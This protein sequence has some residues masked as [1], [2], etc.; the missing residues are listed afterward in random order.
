VRLPKW[1]STAPSYRALVVALLVIGVCVT[2]AI[3]L[4]YMQGQARDRA[5]RRLANANQS[6]E[7]VVTSL[8]RDKAQRH[9][10]RCKAAE[11]I[12]DT[13]DLVKTVPSVIGP[14]GV[15]G[16]QG[17][18][19]LPGAP[20]SNGKD[21]PPGPPGGDGKDGAPG[22]VG[23]PGADGADGPPGPQGSQGPPGPQGS[24]GPPGPQGLTGPAG[25]DGTNGADGSPG[26]AGYPDSFDFTWLGQTYHCTDADNDHTY[27]CSNNG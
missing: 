7:N 11:Q 10:P 24:Q 5:I 23:A 15:Q 19:G 13:K 9:D 25:K 17:I 16:I 22:R 4:L 21:G 20:G 27:T 1:R 12:P 6:N 14:Q 8:C 26:P 2:S 18:P 3:V